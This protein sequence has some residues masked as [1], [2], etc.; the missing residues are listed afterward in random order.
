MTR[1]MPSRCA[2]LS[3]SIPGEAARGDSLACELYQRMALHASAICS[4]VSHRVACVACVRSSTL[5]A[6]FNIALLFTRHLMLDLWH[7]YTIHKM[8]AQI[9][10]MRYDSSGTTSAAH[11]ITAQRC[12]TLKASVE[13]RVA[14]QETEMGEAAEHGTW[15]QRAHVYW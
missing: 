14:V 15:V 7:D 12:H 13:M 4:C 11:R 8:R 9:R 3:V 10:H 6:T 5:A 1:I 2:G